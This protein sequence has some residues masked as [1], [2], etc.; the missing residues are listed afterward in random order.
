MSL[1]IV[2]SQCFRAHETCTTTLNDAVSLTSQHWSLYYVNLF[3]T[4]SMNEQ[5]TASGKIHLILFSDWQHLYI[6]YG[7]NVQN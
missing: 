4:Y 7:Y 6:I 3:F 2:E 5:T 1:G